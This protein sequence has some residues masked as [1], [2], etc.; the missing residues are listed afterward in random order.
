MYVQMT[1]NYCKTY[2]PKAKNC[3]H[4]FFLVLKQYLKNIQMV[5]SYMDI[6]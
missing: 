4:K 5:E 3:N 2:A 6:F 1:M